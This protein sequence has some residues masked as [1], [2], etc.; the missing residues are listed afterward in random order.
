VGG[1]GV[2]AATATHPILSHSSSSTSSISSSSS[3]NSAGQ[4]AKALPLLPQEA[5]GTACNKEPW[6]LLEEVLRPQS[7]YP[8]PHQSQRAAIVRR[9]SSLS[10]AAAPVAIP[11]TRT[12]AIKAYINQKEKQEGKHPVFFKVDSE[13]QEELDTTIWG[14][15]VSGGVSGAIAMGINVAAFMWLRTIMSYQ[16]AHGTPL[17]ETVGVLY[18][19]GGVRRFYQ[20]LMPALIHGPASRFGDTAANAGMLALLDRHVETKN[21]PIVLKTAA[22][23]V[24]SA[25][26]RILIMPLDTIIIC[27]QV[28]GNPGWSSLYRKLVRKGPSVLFQG[29]GASFSANVLG[30]FP[31]FAIYNL[32][33]SK[34]PDPR[35]M[36]ARLVRN[37]FIG[38]AASVVSDVLSNSLTV[39]KVCKQASVELLT[40]RQTTEQILAVGGV[41]GLLG[42]GLGLR[43]MANGFQGMAFGVVWK[44]LDDCIFRGQCR[45]GLL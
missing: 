17:A 16:Q 18:R 12:H 44:Y 32:C 43:L 4:A 39:I 14:R 10:P 36:K 28:Q 8:P 20:G 21:L 22:G 23:S 7:A 41:K 25:V 40:Y 30:H 35:D 1:I 5:C 26:W 31:W 33:E 19:Q 24:A 42:R 2:R 27:Q 38:F 11:P 9:H 37:A 3:I 45:E 29:A 6:V 13:F 15:T 34:L